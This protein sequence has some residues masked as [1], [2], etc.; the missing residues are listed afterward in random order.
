MKLVQKDPME[1]EARDTQSSHPF[2]P[3]M[4]PEQPDMQN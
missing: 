4:R 2:P 3:P 1:E